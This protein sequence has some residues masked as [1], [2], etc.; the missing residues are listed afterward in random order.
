MGTRDSE[1]IYIWEEPVMEKSEDLQSLL[2]GKNSG[3]FCFMEKL[4]GIVY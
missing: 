1:T 3:I 4:V 2:L